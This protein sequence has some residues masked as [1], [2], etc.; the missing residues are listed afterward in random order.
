MSRIQIKNGMVYDGLGNLPVKAD[1]WIFNDRIEKIAVRNSGEEN[2]A[3][4]KRADE[5]IDACLLY[6]S[7]SPRD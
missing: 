5:V 3:E 2:L 7:P 1:V 4:T 6:T